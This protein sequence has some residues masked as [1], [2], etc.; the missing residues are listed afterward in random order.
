MLLDFVH[1][2]FAIKSN[3]CYICSHKNVRM[4]VRFSIFLILLLL[5]LHH[6]SAE[7][8]IV[9]EISDLPFKEVNDIKYDSEGLLWIAT[10]NGLFSYDGF[11]L[12]HYR[13]DYHH[14]NYLSDNYVRRVVADHQDR[15]WIATTK[16]LDRLDK[17][18]ELLE[19]ID[20]GIIRENS[21][22]AMITT[23]DGHVWI[24]SENGFV[25]Y[26]PVTNQFRLIKLPVPDSAPIIGQ[27]IMEDHRGNIWMGTWNLGLFMLDKLTQKI[28]K[29]PKLNPRNSAHVLLED[30][31]YR[32]WVAGWGSGI[33]I[34]QNAWDTE[35]IETFQLNAPDLLSNY[36]YCMTLDKEKHQV[37]VGSSGGITIADTN[38]LG[39][40]TQL[41]QSSDDMVIPGEEVTGII[42]KK[43]G[44]YWVSM[45]G[46]GLVSIESD[47]SHFEPNTLAG[48]RSKM[49]S[50]SVRKIFADKDDYLWMSIGTQGMAVRDLQTGEEY[51]WNEIP[52]L[53][54]KFEHMST[55]YGFTQTFNHRIWIITY[56]SEII[57][58][59]LPQGTRDL[60][61]CECN[62]YQPQSLFAP[63]NQLFYIKE[64]ANDNLWIGGNK[65]VS[66]RQPDGSIVR[67]DTLSLG[68]DLHF[69]DLEVRDQA[70][71]SDGS[72]WIAARENGVIHL[73]CQADKGWKAKCYSLGNG[74]IGDNKIE[75]ICCDRQGNVWA[76]SGCGP[77]YLYNKETKQF[78][79]LNERLRLPGASI[80]FILS[81]P[82]DSTSLW[83]GTNEGLL[84]IDQSNHSYKVHHYTQEDG[85]LDNHLVMGSACFDEKGHLYV[86]THKGYNAIDCNSL[87]N[88]KDESCGI[89]LS[90]LFVN[91]TSWSLLSEKE[92][93]EITEKAPAY[94]NGL[95]LKY[96]QKELLFEFAPKE[97]QENRVVSFAYR[98]DGYDKDWRIAPFKNP[99]A[100]YS[101]LP[102]GNYTFQAFAVSNTHLTLDDINHQHENLFNIRI[103]ILP[104]WWQTWWMKLIY[105]ALLTCVVLLLRKLILRLNARWKR[106]LIAAREKVA[107]RK[108]NMV[109]TPNKPKYTSADEEFMKRVEQCMNRHLSESQFDQQQFLE[110]MGVSKTTCFRR[111]KALTGMNYSNFVR[112]FKINAALKLLKEQPDI[113]ISDLAYSVGFNDPKYFSSCFKK[114]VGKLPSE[115]Q[116]ELIQ[117][118]GE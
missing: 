99:S 68:N 37:F 66:M 2:I 59:I 103:R 31:Q 115:M 106:L 26:D 101:N 36:T 3:F 111:L 11:R 76:G 5:T 107:R 78:V 81:D 58:L 12:R 34:L 13:N 4:K 44:Q 70:F 112:N 65:G 83:V 105:G 73:S 17:Q 52:A 20:L 89:R 16:G 40:T 98:L 95:T 90:D 104:P 116:S 63:S 74:K 43:S 114:L 39:H 28:I 19:H 82:I 55:V 24:A 50:S 96:D 57:E 8:Y 91:G 53:Q 85:L 77:L 49:H 71:G 23:S 48:I 7:Y 35:N 22:T 51:L 6:A 108:G 94:T 42:R 46:R 80:S 27:C 100:L 110:E 30:E 15:V 33:T 14:I 41:R 84:L 9:N 1:I 54:S 97:I 38:N 79:S 47:L 118:K 92:R 109:L 29:F 56:G 45:I 69:R 88:Q 113:R 18:R 60:Q 21:I 75:N 67:F 86:G 87:R 93:F 72:A 10:R 61:K 32:I 62:I 64:D 117:N 102:A 25:D